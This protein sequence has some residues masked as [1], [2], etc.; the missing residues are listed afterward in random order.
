ME[1]DK[2]EQGKKIRCNPLSARV[3]EES[4]NGNET[5]SRDRRGFLLGDGER[6]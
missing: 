6:G 3:M 1:C 4:G 2:R 5:P